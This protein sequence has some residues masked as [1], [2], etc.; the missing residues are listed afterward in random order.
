MWSQIVVSLFV[1]VIGLYAIQFFMPRA[2]R[3]SS[4]TSVRWDVAPMLGFFGVLLLALSL[5]EA[6]RRTVIESWAGGIL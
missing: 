5:M 1:L 4:R 3:G 6:L 2:R